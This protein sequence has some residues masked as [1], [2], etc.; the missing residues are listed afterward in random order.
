MTYLELV[1][2]LQGPITTHD[3]DHLAIGLT[4]REDQHNIVQY[5]H[6][7][8][9]R[10]CLQI[11]PNDLIRTVQQIF[12]E[13]RLPICIADWPTIKHTLD[14]PY[15][16]KDLNVFEIT[17]RAS[18]LKLPRGLDKI[19]SKEFPYEQISYMHLV[20]QVYLAGNLVKK[21]WNEKMGPGN[22]ILLRT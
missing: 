9:G 22:E 21:L 11:K 16:R 3:H 1:M 19:L 20:E 6:P 12:V 13:A 17:Y 10:G 8:V 4:Y 18:I 14:L 5:Y 7:K 15:R 2:A